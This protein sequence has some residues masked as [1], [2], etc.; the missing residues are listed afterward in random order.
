[1]QVQVSFTWSSSPEPPAAE[2]TPDEAEGNIWMNWYVAP[3]ASPKAWFVL[4]QVNCQWYREMQLNALKNHTDES[5]H[6]HRLRE[7]E[8]GRQVFTCAR[9]HTHPTYAH[10]DR[11]KQSTNLQTEKWMRCGFAPRRRLWTANPMAMCPRSRCTSFPMPFFT[12]R[13]ATVALSKLSS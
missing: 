8:S 6:M 4:P 5:A 7:R 11:I 2:A 1:M 13:T 3:A 10:P 9:T 12:A